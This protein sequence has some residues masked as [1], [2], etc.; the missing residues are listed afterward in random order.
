MVRAI[1]K[2]YSNDLRLNISSNYRK[3][4]EYIHNIR[5]QENN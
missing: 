1:L 4:K 3:V 5:N 2:P